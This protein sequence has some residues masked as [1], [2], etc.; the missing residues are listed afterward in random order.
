[1]DVPV[2]VTQEEGRTGFLHLPCAVLASI[3][4]ARSIQASLSL[5]D[6]EVDVMYPQNNRSPLLI[7]HDAV[8]VT[9]PRFELTS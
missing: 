9:A 7:G 2:G 8:R 3:F 6:R 4:L 5:I 1:M